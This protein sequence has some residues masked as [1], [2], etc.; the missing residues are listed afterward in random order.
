MKVTYRLQYLVHFRQYR[1]DV[2]IDQA[3]GK[4]KIKVDTHRR[5][6]RQSDDEGDPVVAKKRPADNRKTTMQDLRGRAL[7]ASYV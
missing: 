5:E 7:H 2:E 6:R 1:G 3:K 4:I